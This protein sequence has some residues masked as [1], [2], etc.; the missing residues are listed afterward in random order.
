V[1]L[2]TAPSRT[3]KTL[4]TISGAFFRFIDILC[5][6]SGSFPI[7]WKKLKIDSAVW[8]GIFFPTIKAA[9]LISAIF[10]RSSKDEDNISSDVFKSTL[11]PLF[12]H[13]EICFFVS[14]CRLS[15]SRPHRNVEL[16]KE[17]KQ[18]YGSF[19]IFSSYGL[20]CL[21]SS[22]EWQ[23]SLLQI[24]FSIAFVSSGQFWILFRWIFDSACFETRDEQENV[25]LQI[26]QKYEV[27]S[28]EISFIQDL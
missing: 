22:H 12:W 2:L 14:E 3:Y 27:S 16:Q 13:S 19:R 9:N 11:K 7:S 28:F 6:I 15:A 8:N 5:K 23:N 1:F 4:F 18:L 21:F 20:N 26:T 17:Q 10:F 24:S 25:L